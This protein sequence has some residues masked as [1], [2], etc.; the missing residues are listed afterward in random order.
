MVRPHPHVRCS[1]NGLR[2]DTIGTYADDSYVTNGCDGATIFADA[3]TDVLAELLGPVD[4]DLY[5]AVFSF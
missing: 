3:G 2:I 1:G 5:L 4:R